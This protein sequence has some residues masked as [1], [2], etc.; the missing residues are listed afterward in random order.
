MHQ[1]KLNCRRLSSH[2]YVSDD[3]IFSMTGFMSKGPDEVDSLRLL[4][5][6]VYDYLNM[7]GFGGVVSLLFG[8]PF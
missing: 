7:S 1:W 4:T 2:S 3:P 5:V 8:V 6:M